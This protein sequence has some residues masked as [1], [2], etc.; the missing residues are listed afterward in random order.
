MD[1]EAQNFGNV[2]SGV[3][4]WSTRPQPGEVV[5]NMRRCW[6]GNLLSTSSCRP[7]CR[8]CKISRFAGFANA[9]CRI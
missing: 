3:G 9:R 4:R 2:W 1:I 7:S 8:S 5:K 6:D